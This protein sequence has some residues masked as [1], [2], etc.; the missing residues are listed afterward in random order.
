MTTPKTLAAAALLAVLLWPAAGAAT[1]PGGSDTPGGGDGCQYGYA[2]FRSGDGENLAHQPENPDDP[3]GYNA[4]AY[5]HPEEI[6]YADPDNPLVKQRCVSPHVL[7]QYE[8]W[9]RLIWGDSAM[10]VRQ[11]GEFD[12]SGGSTVKVNVTV[13]ATNPDD[14][15]NPSRDF[16]RAPG[17]RGTLP[18]CPPD[19]AGASGKQG[20]HGTGGDIGA[21]K[22]PNSYNEGYNP[23]PAGPSGN[24]EAQE[25]PPGEGPD[26]PPEPPA[27]EPQPDIGTPEGDPGTAPSIEET[28]ADPEQ[29]AEER[30]VD[31]R[32]GADGCL[33]QT[34]YADV[35]RATGNADWREVSQND[36]V[37]ALRAY[38]RC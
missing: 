20:S 37:T 8:R 15:P 3:R 34:E 11:A 30:F 23:P 13:P 14:G 28:P 2:Y 12:P 31:D 17:Q 16:C 38:P 6:N 32:A 18:P 29:S 36:L 19:R 24:N 22:R 35:A 10:V 33:D 9:L 5:V 27:P 21:V 25:T 7:D 1:G 4:G 26:S